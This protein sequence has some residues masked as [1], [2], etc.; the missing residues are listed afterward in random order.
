M[1]AGISKFTTRSRSLFHLA[2]CASLLFFVA[3]SEVAADP[4][5]GQRGLLDVAG[6]KSP[7]L[8]QF[9][10]SG[11]DFLSI[12]GLTFDAKDNLY[13]GSVMGQAIYQ[14]DVDT[15][16][17]SVFVSPPQ[18]MADDLE[19]G[20][21]GTA[22]WSSI[23]T[24]KVHARRPDG[25]VYRVAD[26]LPG[27]NAVAFH[28]DGRLFVTQILWGDA[29]W[30]LDI[31]GIKPP[32]KVRADLGYLNGFDFDHDGF[33]YGPL[34][35][36][37]EVVRM[38]VDSGEIKTLATGF[39]LPVAVNLDSKDNVYVADG[40]LGRLVKID[41]DTGAQTLVA[42][43]DSGIDNLAINSRDEVFI[44]NLVDNAIL[45]INTRT[46]ASRTLLRSE[47]SV[48]GGIDVVSNG[49]HDTIYLADLFTY[50]SIDGETGEVK[51]IKRG[52]DA[53]F[54]WPMAVGVQG[55]KVITSSWFADAVEIF[56]RKS[57]KSL[58]AYHNLVDPVDALL[59]ADGRILVAE[60]GTGRLL[61][62][63]PKDDTERQV[64]ASDLPGMAALRPFS[65]TEIYLSDIER[66]ELLRI[67]IDTGEKT[68]VAG[69]LDQPEGFD[70]AADGSIVLA[71]VGK[72]R[73]VR[74]NPVDG[75]VAEIA[76]NLAI[77]YPAA[78]GTPAVYITTGVGVSAS[79]AIYVT[80]D[81][82][83]AVY[84]ITKQ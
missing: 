70:V 14:V 16:D 13:V 35:L 1:L 19:F 61:A 39:A 74:I 20:P 7:Y 12:H 37:G 76:G 26:N 18:G 44:T 55:N 58:A 84:K 5:T 71:E 62:L 56:D 3:M 46:G 72:R 25:T 24:G 49:S 33:L 53:H 51:E 63:S 82:N 6:T 80:S 45:K 78:E 81:L 83:T 2:I 75:Q 67:N 68:V 41:K 21:D 9:L 31:N 77:G 17:V 38:D 36:K 60:Q 8:V 52:L 57:G 48:P 40:K 79:G 29:L 65:K 42:T 69:G 34:N 10:I 4:A 64:I 11:S 22:V 32:R 23:L 28:P 27:V 59:L 30:E 43:V 73:I 15:A 66:G 50:S 54:E 47:L